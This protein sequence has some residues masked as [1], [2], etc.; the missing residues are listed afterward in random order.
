MK[1]PILLS[2][3]ISNPIVVAVHRKD[4]TGKDLAVLSVIRSIFYPNCNYIIAND[5]KHH[6]L[7]RNLDP[8]CA[9]EGGIDNLRLLRL[10]S[11][12][13]LLSSPCILWSSVK[14]W[15]ST[16]ALKM[17]PR[18]FTALHVI[19]KVMSR[20]L[21]IFPILGLMATFFLMLSIRIDGGWPGLGLLRGLRVASDP[22]LQ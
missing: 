6:C 21:P 15:I 13:L 5:R 3:P 9:S 19:V 7:A 17:S 20:L 11:I 14:D 10:L 22:P 16:K 8:G 18:S 12:L 2:E 4:I 1:D